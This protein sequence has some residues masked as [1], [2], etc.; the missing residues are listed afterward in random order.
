[1][2][3]GR[4]SSLQLTAAVTRHPP[5]PA[6]AAASHDGQQVKLALLALGVST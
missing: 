6:Q 3:K 1:M 5:P 2:L 4:A